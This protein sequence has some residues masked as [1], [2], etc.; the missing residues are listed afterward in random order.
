MKRPQG[1]SKGRRATPPPTLGPTSVRTSPPPGRS[2]APP[3]TPTALPAEAPPKAPLPLPAEGGFFIID[4]PRGPTSHQVTAWVRDLLGV[5]RAGHAG[6]LDP[7][8]SGVLVISVGKALRLL[9]LL[10]E[11]P[12]RYIAVIRFHGP[13]GASELER[14]V[15]EFQGPIFQLP[16]VR[17]AVRR[18]RRVRVIHKLTLL[19]RQGRDAL[20]DIQCD[21]GTYIRTLAVDMGEALGPGANMIELRR[22][23]TGPFN[24]GEILTL[25]QLA[26]A[27]AA[28]REG[29]PQALLSHLHA[30]GKVWHRFP[31]VVVKDS[32]VDA[33]AHGADLAASGVL[34]LSGA[35][36]E[37]QRVVLVTRRDELVGLGR[38]LMDSARILHTKQG[39]VIDAQQVFM[40]PGRYA[41]HVKGSPPPSGGPGKADPPFE[42][43]SP[44]PSGASPPSD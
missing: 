11:F 23:G 42:T 7:G 37:G 24:E 27:V 9:P 19:E 4:K 8:V 1:P 41:R 43:G 32:A 21:S 15:K 29:S 40:E 20:L 26:D 18:E 14:V 17:S 22:T 39:W 38:A 12:K 2:A 10:L 25:S 44:A 30:P 36:M 35:F 33:L 3:A 5:S 6:T 13:V 34:K 16:P 31:Q 28:A